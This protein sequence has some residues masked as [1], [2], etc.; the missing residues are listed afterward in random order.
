LAELLEMANATKKTRGTKRTRAKGKK[1]AAARTVT[2]VAA[3]SVAANATIHVDELV[4]LTG[5]GDR[6]LRQLAHEGFF[7]VPEMNL[8]VTLPTL[9]GLI[10]FYRTTDKT[11]SIQQAKLRLLEA[12]LKEKNIVIGRLDDS[13]KPISFFASKTFALGEEIKATLNF[14]L[15]DRLPALNAGLDAITQRV[16][17]R[18]VFLLVLGRFQDFAKQW[19]S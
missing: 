12:Q 5:L 1:K 6:R 3:P 13:L 8:Y 4:A 17:N 10:R 16:N 7:P 14:Q 11:E 2:P 18:A 19:T 9:V 15:N